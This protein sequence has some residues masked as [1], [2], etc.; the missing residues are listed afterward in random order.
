MVTSLQPTNAKLHILLHPDLGLRD[1]LQSRLA[2]HYVSGGVNEVPWAVVEL[3]PHIQEAHQCAKDTVQG[4]S[5]SHLSGYSFEVGRRQRHTSDA[6]L[7]HC[8]LQAGLW[9]HCVWHSIE[10][11]S[12]TTSQHP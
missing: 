4:G 6:V 1:P 3:T 9:L 7:D 11:R 8:L 12:T 2:T 5:Q 10:H